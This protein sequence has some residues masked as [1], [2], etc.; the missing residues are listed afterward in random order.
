MFD[1]SLTL[2]IDGGNVAMPRVSQDKYSSVYRKRTTTRQY[3]LQIRHTSKKQADG[4]SIDRHNVELIVTKIYTN[5]TTNAITSTSI[6]TY[7]V[8]E[9]PSNVDQGGESVSAMNALKDSFMTNDFV[10]RL[11]GFES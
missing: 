9:C 1:N 8:F 5:A 6:K 10:T 11:A 7:F 2:S 3:D 4:T